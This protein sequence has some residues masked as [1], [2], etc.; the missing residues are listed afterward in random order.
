ML[1]TKTTVTEMKYAFDGP[2]SGLDTDKKMISELED[3]ALETP[4]S[5][6][7]KENKDWERNSTKYPRT[8]GQLHKYRVCRMG[9][10]EGE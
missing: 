3:M 1:E 7:Q 5:E 4:K 6:K 10:S 8:V 2:I 9:I